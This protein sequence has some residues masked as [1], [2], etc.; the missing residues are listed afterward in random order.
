MTS[1][2]SFRKNVVQREHDFR[3]IACEE[4]IDQFEIV[5]IVEHIEV[6]DGLLTS[7]EVKIPKKGKVKA[8][9]V[10]R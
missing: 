5:F 2:E 7:E 4:E 8:Y 1:F 6:G 10:V 3:N 9:R